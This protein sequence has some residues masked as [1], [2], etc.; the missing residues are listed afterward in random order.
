MKTRHGLFIGFAVLIVT[1]IFTFTGCPTDSS[2]DENNSIVGTWMEQGG[3]IIEFTDIVL[4]IE[5]EELPYK[6][7]GT[8][9]T[10]DGTSM[11]LGVMPATAIV[12]GSTLILSGFPQ[13]GPNGTWTRQ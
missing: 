12:S 7:S 3:Y 6:L 9:L 2:D 10:V 8:T 1:A 13:G 11:G 4:K 5:G